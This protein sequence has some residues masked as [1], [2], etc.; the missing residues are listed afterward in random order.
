MITVILV[1]LVLTIIGIGVA[2]FTQVEDRISGNDRL[3]KAGFYAAEAGLRFG[4]SLLRAN[5]ASPNALSNR[6]Q[7]TTGATLNPPGGGYTAH[8][9]DFGVP[10]VNQA[11]S[12]DSVPGWGTVT[13]IDQATFSLFVR[14]NVEDPGGATFETD[15]RTNLI[16]VGVIQ[17]ANGGGIT[18]ILEEQ[19]IVQIAGSDSGTQKQG[20]QGGTGGGAVQ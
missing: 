8:V 12:M 3:M 10:M 14:N 6:Y 15:N 16:A 1:I 19:I 2:Y 20:N 7:A 18:K 11:V 9:I 5:V 17:L 4:E 13:N